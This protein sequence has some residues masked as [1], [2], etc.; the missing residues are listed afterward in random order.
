MGGV[1][2]RLWFVFS[3]V[4]ALVIHKMSSKKQIKTL[5]TTSGVEVGFIAAQIAQIK[6]FSKFLPQNLLK[7]LKKMAI[8]KEM[9]ARAF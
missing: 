5:C 9:L 1:A 7:Y 6:Y 2:H 3:L 8:I 4:I